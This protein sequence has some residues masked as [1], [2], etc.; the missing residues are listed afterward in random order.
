MR[1]YDAL[2]GDTSP[3]ALEQHLCFLGLTGMID[4]VRPEVVD[5]IRACRSAGIRPDHDHR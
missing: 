2:P 4:P 1:T 5:A 3:A